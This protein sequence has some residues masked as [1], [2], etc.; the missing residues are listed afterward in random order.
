MTSA[1][2]EA[3]ADPHLK[4][5]ISSTSCADMQYPRLVETV[6]KDGVE[7]NVYKQAKHSEIWSREFSDHVGIERNYQEYIQYVDPAALP[8][9]YN[10]CDMNGYNYCTMNRNQHIPQYCGS[11]WAHGA[12]SALGDRIKIA[13]NAQGADINLSVQQIL[14]CAG[15]GTC[16]GGSVPGVYAWLRA[17]SVVGNTGLGYETSQPY[18]ACSYESTEGFCPS[19]NW[20]CSPI[21]I[22]RTCNTFTSSGGYCAAIDFYPNVTISSYGTL[23]FA[24]NMQQEIYA[25]GPISCGIDAVPILTYQT[26]IVSQKGSGVD[27]VVSITGWGVENN[28]TYWHVRNSWGE[29][30]GEM[31]YLRVEMGHNYLNLESECTYAIVRDF[32]VESNQ[33]HCFEDGSNCQ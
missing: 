8:A 6:T 27:H 31:G 23:A 15:V 26:G 25:N 32:T 20:D 16:H 11:C 24:S 2:A 18:M 4:E 3:L 22:A 28:V 17:K 14:N 30:W 7:M 5:A 12:V 10:W 13:R 21:N 33:V 19:A 1:Q 9:S 29:Y